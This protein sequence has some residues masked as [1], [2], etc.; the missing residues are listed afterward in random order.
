[1]TLGDVGMRKEKKRQGTYPP[2]LLAW[3]LTFGGPFRKMVFQDSSVRFH[4]N[5]WEA[6]F[7]LRTRVEMKKKTGERCAVSFPLIGLE[8]GGVPIQTNSALPDPSNLEPTK[9][10]G[11]SGFL[12]ELWVL[13]TREV[14]QRSPCHRL[15]SAQVR[16][17]SGPKP[18]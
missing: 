1:M 15:R 16:M 10:S 12:E 5:W 14:D 11:V 9:R 18:P 2:T 13:S 7:L 6:E 17:F 4:V 3:N 8:L